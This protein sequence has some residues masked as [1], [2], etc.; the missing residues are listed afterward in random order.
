MGSSRFL[1]RYPTQNVDDK[2]IKL[3]KSETISHGSILLLD[4]NEFYHAMGNSSD[5][6]FM[7]LHI[8]GSQKCKGSATDNSQIFEIEKNKITTTT[9]SAYLNLPDELCKKSELGITFNN[10]LKEDYIK[11]ASP[12]FERISKLNLLEELA[13]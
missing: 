11:F 12:Y 6:P 1:W 8:Y 4:N 5:T 9:G 13:R 7:T 2:V 10:E 3:E